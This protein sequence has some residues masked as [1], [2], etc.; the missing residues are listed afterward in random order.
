MVVY[1]GVI[2][3]SK[4]NFEVYNLFHNSCCMDD[5]FHH[6]FWR[7][8]FRDDKVS[9]IYTGDT[10]LNFVKI[11]LIFKNY[12]NS[13]GLI[14]VPHHGDIN[15]FN[16][17]ILDSQKLCPIS[18]GKNNSYGHPSDKVVIDILSNDSCP[19]FVTEDKNSIFVQV[20]KVIRCL[21]KQP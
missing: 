7:R 12:W 15:S 4:H 19:I 10:D 1:S 11:Q 20:I 17:D 14:Q 5:Y 3:N 2:D 16:T 6:R 13:V 18:A 9:C 21:T 8:H